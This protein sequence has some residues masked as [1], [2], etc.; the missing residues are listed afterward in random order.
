MIL[1]KL[2]EDGKIQSGSII[3][4]EADPSK[5]Q[6]LLKMYESMSFKIRAYINIDKESYNDRGALMATTVGKLMDWCKSEYSMD[7]GTKPQNV[8]FKNKNKKNK[9]RQLPYSPHTNINGGRKTTKK[10]RK[11]RKKKTK[12]K[13]KSKKFIK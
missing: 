7:G 10:K 3:A 2:I 9:Y 4:L 6:K 12:S 11:K 8:S 5:D 13:S 1:K